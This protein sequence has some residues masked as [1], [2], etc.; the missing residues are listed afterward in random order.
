MTEP[1]DLDELARRYVDLWQDQITALAADSEFTETMGRL[2]QLSASMGPAAWLS[3]WTAAAAG[4]KPRE[5]HDRTR[6]REPASPPNGAAPAAAAPV[7]GGDDLAELRRRLAV[8]EE[9]VARDPD[10][11]AGSGKPGRA[12]VAPLA[13]PA[14]GRTAARPRSRRP[15]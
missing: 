4:L 6:P 11:R 7:D 8:L 14:G 1:P 9:R 13:P 12:A 15:R 2:L 3:L 5:T 10:G